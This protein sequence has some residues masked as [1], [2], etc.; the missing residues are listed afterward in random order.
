MKLLNKLMDLLTTAYIW[1]RL[2]VHNTWGIINVFN[3]VWIRPMTGGLLKADHPMVTGVNPEN[4]EFIWKQNIIFQSSRSEKFD[5]GPTDIEI[6]CDVGHHMRKMVEVS[7][8]SEECPNG[9]ADRMPP[10]INYIHGCVHY[11]GGFLLFNDFKDAISHFSNIDFQKSFKQFVREEGREPVTIFRNRNYDRMEYLE[12]VCFLRTIF[13]WFSNSNGNKKRIGWGN[14]APYPTVNTITGYWMVDTYKL[15]TEEGRRSVCR[16]A[17]TKKY[18]TE[19][20]YVGKRI[21]TKPDEKF[22]A[23]FTNKRVLA[24]GDK[25]NMFFVDL[26]KLSQGYKFDPSKKLPNI[27]DR[28]MEKYFNTTA[29]YDEN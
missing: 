4:G 8:S 22:L 7:S 25:G 5:S 9:K 18:F 26:R 1:T 20:V 29:Y 12:F 28:L 23:H 17:V 10:A 19:K 11:N 24:R 27:A 3:I 15:Y 21:T 6:V 14:P 16:S 2:T 13:P